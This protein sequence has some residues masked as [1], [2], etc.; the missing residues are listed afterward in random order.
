MIDLSEVGRPELEAH[1]EVRQLVVELALRRVKRRGGFGTAGLQ[2]EV[3][4]VLVAKGPQM[5]MILFG[6]RCE[7]PQ[8]ER[9]GVVADRDFNLGQVTVDRELFDQRAQRIDERRDA[10]VEHGALVHV[11]HVSRATF[12]EADHHAFL[13]DAAHRESGTMPVAPFVTGNH[14]QYALGLHFADAQQVL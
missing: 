11:S 6:E 9:R 4:A 12:A 3:H 8:D 14:R 7:M 13:H 5:L 2:P 10:R 1:G